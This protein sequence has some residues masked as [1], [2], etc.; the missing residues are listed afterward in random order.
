MFKTSHRTFSSLLASTA[1]ILLA[2][3]SG[4][5]KADAII[6]NAEFCVDATDF[7]FLVDVS[8]PQIGTNGHT[9]MG[10]FF[11][12]GADAPVFASPDLQWIA[13][14]FDLE[15]E[16][17]TYGP[18]VETFG[19][20]LKRWLNEDPIVD[21]MLT[22]SVPGDFRIEGS[23]PH[24]PRPFVAGDTI[25]SVVLREAAFSH[26]TKDTFLTGVPIDACDN[27]ISDTATLGDEV[28]LGTGIII[29]DFVDIGDNVVLGDQVFIGRNAI[30]G[31]GTV[32]GDGAQ[33]ARDVVIGDRVQGLTILNTIF[34]P[35]VIDKGAR[36]G[37]DTVLEATE[38]GAGAIVG[39]GVIARSSKTITRDNYT[40]V[41][42][43]QCSLGFHFSGCAVVSPTDLLESRK[44]YAADDHK[45][46][47]I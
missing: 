8:E 30:I 1:M 35:V 28:V 45:E 20:P 41:P 38:I 43:I 31:D 46:E 19:R 24:G 9:N 10:M 4:T 37:D 12:I 29:E 18:V 23:V 25:N 40:V 2:G 34:H 27:Q 47:S 11:R 3:V 14:S 13:V 42:K 16:A 7:R 21:F 33:I 26:G 6:A 5:A 32:L 17:I 44:K 22:Q 15:T 39:N 36:V